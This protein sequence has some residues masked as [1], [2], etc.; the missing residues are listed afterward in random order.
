[1]SHSIKDGL[2]VSFN[3]TLK[4]NEGETL[5]ESTQ[6]LEYIHGYGNIIP[7]LEKELTGLN[8]GDKKSVEVEP[9]EGYGEYNEELLFDVPRANFPA[10][11]SIQVGMQFQTEMEEGPMIVTVVEVGDENITV[12]GNHSL[13]GEILHFDVS[14][15]GIREATPQELE[16]GHVHQGGHDH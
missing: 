1:M 16:H 7:G 3:Y 12:D 15:E 2:V 6:A 8:I 13:A 5:E 9:A 4:N 11:M 10:D 14:I